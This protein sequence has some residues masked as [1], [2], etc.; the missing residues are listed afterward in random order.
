MYLIRE[1]AITLRVFVICTQIPASS[2]VTTDTD[3][4]SI[5]WSGGSCCLC[6]V[7]PRIQ[8]WVCRAFFVSFGVSSCCS[9]GRHLT[10]QNTYVL[11]GRGVSSRFGWL[12]PTGSSNCTVRFLETEGCWSSFVLH[13]LLS[14]VM[15]LIA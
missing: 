9:P 1:T 6:G 5:G 15:Q 10:V 7:C 3:V 14:V 2:D 13:E 8:I 11:G 4:G 12:C